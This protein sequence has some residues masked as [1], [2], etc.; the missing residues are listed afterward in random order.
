MSTSTITERSS[1][2]EHRA[3]RAAQPARQKGRRTTAKQ[4]PSGTPAA[5]AAAAVPFHGILAVQDKH[6]F[7]RTSGYFAG[8]DDVH[9]SLTQVN[10]YG[11]R[12]GD[13]VSGTAG[14]AKSGRDKFTSL[15]SLDTVNGLPP[16]EALNRP[17]FA[18]LTPLFPEERL[19]LDT[20]PLATRVI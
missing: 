13:A 1:T 2:T 17:E 10:A 7:V 15:V 8:P 14:L 20:G 16:E 5:T 6:A 9:V 3:H 12:T 4:T 19:R 11:L 18:K